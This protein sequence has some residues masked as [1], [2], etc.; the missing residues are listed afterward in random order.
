MN[1]LIALDIETTGL[2]PRK[3]RIHGIG[4]AKSVEEAAYLD[5]NDQNLREYLANPENH[6][7]GHN[8]RFDLKFLVQAGFA[9]NCQIWD[10]KLLAQLLDE[11]QELGLKP[12]SQK[13]FGLSALENKR[14]LDRAVSSINGRSVADLCQR[15]LEDESEPFYHLIAKY[16]IEDCINTLRLFYE[17]SNSI[18]RIHANM[19][20]AGYQYTPLTYYTDETMP[21]ERVLMNMELTG[22]RIDKQ[23]LL[24]YRDRL[25]SENKQHMA[26]MSLLA[27]KEINSIEEDL[28]AK[29]IETKKTDKGKA[30]V[31]KR[32]EKHGTKFNW[33]SSDHLSTL[34]FNRFG[35]PITAVEKTQTGKPS[36]SESSLEVLHKSMD[37]NN[38]LARILG[39]YKAW[40]KNVKLITTYTG[41]DKGLLSQ[42]EDDRVYAEYLQAGRG[43]EGTTGGTVTG[44]LS[45]RNPNMQNLPRG[46]EI[47][48]F[49]IPDPGHVFVY[50]DYSQ[51]EL[52]LA[53]HLSQD[54]LLIKA[55]KEG[56]DLHE[57]TA[58]A[59]GADRQTGKSTNFAMI[60]DAS[61]WRLAEMLNK[62][63]ED[64]QAIINEFYH[65]YNGY[66][67]YLNEQR[68]FITQYGCVVAPT[69]RI[70]RLPDI[71]NT[72]YNSKEWRHAL[73]QGYNFPIQS[74]GASI[75]KRAM[76]ELTKR[77]VTI[78][79]QVHDSVIIMLPENKLEKVKEIQHVAETVYPLSVPLKADIKL[80]TSLS[81]SDILTVKESTHEQCSNNQSNQA[82]S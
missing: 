21:L 17:L 18:K 61:A 20:K 34:I 81:E 8:I 44:R 46:S 11:N 49:F 43:K 39:T 35:V 30:N 56:L 3:D 28:Y 41:D 48:R 24:D 40:K 79:T 13:Y 68:K 47:K 29:V 23:K 26:Q 60:Y 65:L 54:P 51:L 1:K 64:C 6:I 77:G 12:L 72:Q 62:S 71:H 78:L 50:F 7:V 14:E 80:L 22:I 25:L 2:N 4:V 73:K 32:S 58:Q 42:I 19:I 70:R 67:N 37:P 36:T 55:Y 45:S 38:L 53:A 31:Q 9:I 59:I 76:I 63:K 52:R 15:D 27:A 5:V 66:R 74:L 57:I 16:C 33:Q 82:R 69:G 10:T 75:T